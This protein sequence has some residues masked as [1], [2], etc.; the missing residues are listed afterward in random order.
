MQL[1]FAFLASVALAASGV[2]PAAAESAQ[3]GVAALLARS[4][5]AWN[6][7]DLDTFMQTYENSA[8]TQYIS[9]TAIV[10]GYGAIRARYA[11]HY[12]PGHMGALSVS[13]LVVRPLG[14]RYAV[15]SA[16]WHLAR[17]AAA[18]G[19]VS[20]LFTL[21]LHRNSQGWHIITDH[22]P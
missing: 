16:R 9:S 22:T 3:S 7:G 17:T 20:G 18:G 11:G 4:A 8:Q 21:V 2:M 19:N 12:H 13:D 5:S 15:A 6:R 10:H 1:L 14:A